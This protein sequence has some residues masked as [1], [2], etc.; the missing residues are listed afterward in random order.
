L[1]FAGVLQTPEQISAVSGLK[2][3]ILLRRVENILLFNEFFRLSIHTLVAKIQPDKVVGWC[4][5]G[6]LLRHFC[7]LYF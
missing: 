1:K 5:D 2:F 6:D 4:A 7:V 3:A